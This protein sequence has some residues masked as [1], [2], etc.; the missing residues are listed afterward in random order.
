MIRTAVSDIR[1][2]GRNSQGVIVMRTGENVHVNAITRVER[3][4]TEEAEEPEE[5]MESAKTAVEEETN[6]GEA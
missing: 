6:G 5:T 1:L 4:E 2:C 3:E